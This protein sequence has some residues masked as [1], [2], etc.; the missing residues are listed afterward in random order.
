MKLAQAEALVGELADASTDVINAGQLLWQLAIE[1]QAELGDLEDLD[2]APERMAAVIAS[3]KAVIEA[4][5]DLD[6]ARLQAAAAE[7]RRAIG[8][9]VGS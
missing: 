7:L 5:R 8:G 1:L 3:A 4:R 6:V 2:V 9:L